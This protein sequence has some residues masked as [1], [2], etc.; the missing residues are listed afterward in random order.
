MIVRQFLQVRGAVPSSP[1]E[2]ITGATTLT[3]IV[4]VILAILSLLSWGIMFAIWRA[5]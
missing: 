5:H 1:V 4:L 2:L 3:Q